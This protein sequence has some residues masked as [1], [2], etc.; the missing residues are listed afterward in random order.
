MYPLAFAL[1]LGQPTPDTFNPLPAVL[2]MVGKE[3]ESTESIRAVPFAS[4]I[5]GI[6]PRVPVG[7]AR[8]FDYDNYPSL[9][10]IGDKRKATTRLNANWAAMSGQLTVSD[11]DWVRNDPLGRGHS[12]ATDETLKVTVNDSLFVFGAVDMESKSVAQQQLRWLGKTGVGC[13]LRPWMLDE[14][15]LRGG[16]ALRYDDEE[17]TPHGVA[18]ERSELFVEVSTKLPLPFLG[19]VNVEYTGTAIAA[20]TAAERERIKQNVKFALP[21]SDSSQFHVGARWRSDDTAS[22]TPF[23]DRAQLYLGVQLKR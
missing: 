1:W 9:N 14:L 4:P 6:T 18:S 13:K 5:S 21:L 12:W 22:V 8:T 7:S 3:V 2:P 23:I 15:L 20:I 19:A 16:S 17:R 11:P 10:Q